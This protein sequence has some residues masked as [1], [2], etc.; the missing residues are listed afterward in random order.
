MNEPEQRRSE[1]GEPRRRPYRRRVLLVLGAIIVLAVLAGVISARR[2]ER[3]AHL[4]LLRDHL[5]RCR[6]MGRVT[7]T[8]WRTLPP[9]DRRALVLVM[10]DL[11]ELTWDASLDD[12]W[13]VDLLLWVL[14]DDHNPNRRARAARAL[15]ELGVRTV[16]DLRPDAPVPAGLAPAV[17]GLERVAEVEPRRQVRS[18]AVAALLRMRPVLRAYAAHLEAPSNGDSEPSGSSR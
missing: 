11:P 3:Q 15:G 18:A 4:D 5:E 1:S 14:H 17:A 2:A 6:Q 10:L 16:L 12:A 8:D 9:G 7:A 13:L